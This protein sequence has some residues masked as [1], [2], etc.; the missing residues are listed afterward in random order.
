MGGQR[1]GRSAAGRRAGDPRLGRALSRLLEWDSAHASLE[2]AV[3][4]LAPALRGRRPRGLPH[5]PWEI[6]EHIRLAQLDILEYCTRPD[7]QERSWPRDFWPAAP[8]PPSG[9]AWAA[10]LRACRR[11]R[12]AL[13]RLARG[14]RSDLLA[15]LPHGRGASLLVELVLAADHAAY[16]VGQLVLVRKALRDWTS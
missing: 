11:D 5:S 16:H 2:K 12:E 14:P 13:Q 7:Y 8:A 1:G 6:L 4:G 3:A 15:P 10:S 9:R